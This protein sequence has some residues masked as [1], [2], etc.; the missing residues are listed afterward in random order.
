MVWVGVR[1]GL[2][3]PFHGPEF[4]SHLSVDWMASSTRS[5][6]L[7]QLVVL[8][9]SGTAPTFFGGELLGVKVGESLVYV[10]KGFHVVNTACFV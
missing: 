8:S 2:P 1:V 9:P 4:R 5:M 3:L 10:V 7:R 6:S